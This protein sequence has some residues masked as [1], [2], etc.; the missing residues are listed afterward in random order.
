MDIFS[1]EF[2]I[3]N[4]GTDILHD[5]PLGKLN[6]SGEGIIRRDEV[7]MQMCIRRKVPIVM[8]LSGGFQKLCAQITADS[9]E[10]LLKKFD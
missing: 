7:M 10:N 3:Y 2:V 1:P 9:I 8:I 6:I 5:D 4:A